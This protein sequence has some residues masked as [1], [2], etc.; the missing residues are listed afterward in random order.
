MTNSADENKQQKLS[1]TRLK[2]TGLP[3][4]YSNTLSSV[5]VWNE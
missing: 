2:L 3:K 5:Q 1:D 4:V